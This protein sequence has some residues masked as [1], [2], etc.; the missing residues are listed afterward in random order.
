[1]GGKAESDTIVSPLHPGTG[2]SS[3]KQFISIWVNKRWHRLNEPCLLRIIPDLPILVNLQVEQSWLHLQ[4]GRLLPVY[5]KA[6]LWQLWP[7]R[8]RGPRILRLV[9][10]VYVSRDHRG[11]F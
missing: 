6:R 3:E 7:V 1:Y 4:L 5:A 9:L 11:I 8:H 10:K 2:R